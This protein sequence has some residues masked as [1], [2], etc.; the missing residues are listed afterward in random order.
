MF[1]HDAARV[2]PVRKDCAMTRSARLLSLAAGGSLLAITAHVGWQ[3]AVRAGIDA[4][5]QGSAAVVT[6]DA[7]EVDPVS[8]RVAVLGLRMQSADGVTITIGR[9]RAPTTAGWLT[10]A[11]AASD[12]S[13]DGISVQG[14]GIEVK[15]PRIDVA[16]TPG[17]RDDFAAI[18]DGNA[19]KPLSQRLAALSAASVSIPE[20]SVRKTIGEAQ[21]SGVYKDIRIVGLNAGVIRSLAASGGTFDGSSPG[22]PPVRG[23]FGPLAAT[24][25][26]TPLIARAYLEPAGPGDTEMKTAYG[27]MSL[28]NLTGASGPEAKFSIAR[29]SGKGFKMKPTKEPWLPLIQDMADKPKLEELSPEERSRVVNGLVDMLESFSIDS[30]EA[31]D[32]VILG[33]GEDGGG[34]ARIARMAYA[35]AQVGKVNEMRVEGIDVTSKDA[36]GRIGLISQSGWSYKNTLAAMREAFGKADSSPE[37]V[38]PRAFIP[39]L[40]SFTLRD[41]D[42]NVPDTAAR[43]KD[44]NAPNLR[45]GLKAF[46]FQATDPLLGIPTALRISTDRLTMAIPPGEK[47]EGLKDLVAMGY[48]ELDLSSAFEARWSEATTDLTIG[49]IGLQGV[50]MGS[51]TLRGLLGNISKEIFSG[52]STSAQIA[53]MGATA[54]QLTLVVENK[55]L[56]EKALEYQAKSRKKSVDQIRKEYAAAAQMGI[57]AMIGA[58]PAAKQIATA[59]AKFVARPN[60]LTISAKARNPGG[61]GLAEVAVAGGEPAAILDGLE[62]TATAE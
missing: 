35:G 52:D 34:R 26:D 56:F 8:G 20:M 10:P 17:T 30:M 54:K 24:D 42:F 3:H 53:L 59:V 43:A 31:A 50:N 57:P 62:V 15:I 25:I 51:V 1:T 6:R 22:K 60:R 16:G 28:E 4:A 33:A 47:Q 21:S 40:G 61:L 7:V 36:F 55:G 14:G 38:N 23:T 12:V 58:S 32:I 13:L 29:L 44:P 39:E 48:K 41:A 2:G 11:F 19:S 18:F 46:E 5:L 9:V 27:A 49:Q 37:D 45:V